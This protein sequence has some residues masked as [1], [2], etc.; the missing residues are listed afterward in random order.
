MREQIFLLRYFNEV[1]VKF[2]M[3]NSKTRFG[4][5]NRYFE[6]TRYFLK[7]TVGTAFARLKINF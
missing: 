4:M 7:F 1:C 6:K 5:K 3:E 2:F